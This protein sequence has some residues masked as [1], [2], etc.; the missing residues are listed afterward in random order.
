[1]RVATN[2]MKVFKIEFLLEI[3]GKPRVFSNRIRASAGYAARD[4]VDK[5]LRDLF[6]ESGLG[7][8]IKSIQDEAEVI[9]YDG[10]L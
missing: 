5:A 8:S 3:D 6:G 1:M 2:K 7:H 10:D 4:R 9:N